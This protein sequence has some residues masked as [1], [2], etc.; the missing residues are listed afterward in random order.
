MGHTYGDEEGP[1]VARVEFHPEVLKICRRVR[2]QVEGDIEDRAGR[3]AHELGLAM[4]LRL[5]MHSPQGVPA[6]VPSHV[7]LYDSVRKAS[8][9]ELSRAPATGEEATLI[10]VPVQV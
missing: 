6:G 8:V 5:P 10:G 4:R 3:A 1:S 2:A 9:R 7:A